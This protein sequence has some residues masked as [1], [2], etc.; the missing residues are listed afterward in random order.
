MGSN[1]HRVPQRPTANFYVD[2]FNLFYGCLKGTQYKWLDLE[3]LFQL[4]VPTH[5]IKRIRYFTARISGRSD[6]PDSPTKQDAYLR[7]LATSPKVTIHYGKFLQ[8]VVRMPLA[9]PR[10]GHK[11]V[12]V[13]KTEEK[14]SDV[15]LATYLLIDAIR[16]DCD[17]AVVVSNDSDLCEPIR[18]VKDEYRVP[19][20]LLNPHLHASSDLRKLS[21]TFQKQ[22]RKGPLAASQFAPQLVNSRGQ[23]ISKP[24]DW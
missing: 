21:P 8:S 11:T 20:G 2:G 9:V 17:L 13:I 18:I 23:K 16:G 24:A 22:I 3:A 15:N 19:V 4:L 6:K 5:D 7:A 1:K 14:G 12:E 10:P